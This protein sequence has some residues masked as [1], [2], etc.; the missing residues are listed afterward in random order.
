MKVGLLVGRENTFPEP[1]IERVNAKGGGEITAELC[2]LGGTPANMQPEYRVIVDRI[3]HEVPYYRQYLKLAMLRGTVLINDPFWWLADDKFFECGLAEDLGIAVP[4]TVVLP[5]KGY[6]EGIS[7]ESLRNLVYPIDW[8]AIVDYVGFPAFLKPSVGGGWRNVYKVH[9]LHELLWAYDQT[10]ELPMILQE[11]IE[12]EGYV[13]CICLGKTNIQPIK[14]VPSAP[15]EQRYQIDEHYL[16]PDL[17]ARILH[18]AQVLNEALGYDMNTVEF[19]I[20][21]GVPYA[22]DWLNPACDFDR[23]SITEYYFEWVLE[24]MSDLVLARAR[25]PQTESYHRY[26]WWDM[27]RG[28][29]ERDRTTMAGVG[30]E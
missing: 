9:S 1:F 12:F 30:S 26:R 16:G 11:S 27:T 18:D 20:R 22:I 10:G 28:V 14:Y 21:G 4:R 8:Q 2:K 15:F 7:S 6:I 25:N 17:R 3:S 23:F 19:A 13:R 24:T 29:R 5:N